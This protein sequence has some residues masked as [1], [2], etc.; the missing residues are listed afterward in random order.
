MQK[1]TFDISDFM[2]IIAYL[3]SYKNILPPNNN[4]VYGHICGSATFTSSL[5]N[6][7]MSILK[8]QPHFGNNYIIF[9]AGY[10]AWKFKL[11]QK[12]AYFL[13]KL[14]TPNLPLCT[15]GLSNEVYNF[16][17]PQGAQKLP[18]KVQMKSPI[19]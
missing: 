7:L 18:A 16:F 14:S 4:I 3:K 9:L 2:H 13:A 17:L 5:M 10:K 15:S 12:S 6:C 19:Y 1:Y 8:S 11:W